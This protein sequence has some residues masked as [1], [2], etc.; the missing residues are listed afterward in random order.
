MANNDISKH[1]PLF[2]IRMVSTLRQE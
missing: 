1:L 2:L